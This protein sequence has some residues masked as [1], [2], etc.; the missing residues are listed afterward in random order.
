MEIEE[1]R[2]VYW[3]SYMSSKGEAAFF[4]FRAFIIEWENEPAL[5][6][7]QIGCN[8]FM[9]ILF[10]PLEIDTATGLCYNAR[11]E[12]RRSFSSGISYFLA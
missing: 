6:G 3:C 2:G 5:T 8:I 7:K 1:K 10:F 9:N 12:Q 11:N 4:P